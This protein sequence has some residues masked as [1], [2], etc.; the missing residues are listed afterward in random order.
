MK[1][2]DCRAAA[3]EDLKKIPAKVYAPLGLLACYLTAIPNVIGIY[4]S[5]GDVN[6]GLT[7][8]AF[9]LA[10]LAYLYQAAFML[11]LKRW[12]A[13]VKVGAA[14]PT[15][16]EVLSGKRIPRLLEY[17]ILQ[18]V[19]TQSVDVV[20]MRVMTDDKMTSGLRFSITTLLAIILIWFLMRLSQVPYLIDDD[21]LEGNRNGFFDEVNE[22]W[23]LMKGRCWSFFFLN[24]SFLG[25]IILQNVTGGLASFFVQPYLALACAEFYS[26]IL[27][28][29]HIFNR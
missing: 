19:L 26:Q 17:A 28:D 14:K 20:S 22:S 27:E 23:R 25:W 16:W 18:S 5:A 10:L 2:A 8:L 15:F 3:R 24:L 9:A 13:H 7:I 6:W 12:R 21:L 29:E 4:A 11:Y 1:A